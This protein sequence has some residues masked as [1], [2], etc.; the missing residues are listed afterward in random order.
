MEVLPAVNFVIKQSSPDV[1]FEA[2]LQDIESLQKMGKKEL[3][4][5][6]LEEELQ[7]W[8]EPQLALPSLS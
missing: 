1:C 8:K 2:W 5:Y 6:V 3:L 4:K 7:K